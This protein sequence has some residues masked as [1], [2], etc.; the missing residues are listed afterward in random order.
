MTYPDADARLY[1]ALVSLRQELL[2]YL[3][4]EHAHFRAELVNLLE[5]ADPSA[6]A[7]TVIVLF[8]RF[9][10]ARLERVVG[11]TR[12]KWMLGSDTATFVLY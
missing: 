6:A 10:A 11:V 12:A 5:S 1:G 4:P 2:F 9:D 7:P 3:L 8:L